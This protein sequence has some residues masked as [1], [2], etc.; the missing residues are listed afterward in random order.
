[1]TAT[2]VLDVVE[3]DSGTLEDA[4][5]IDPTPSRLQCAELALVAF[6]DAVEDE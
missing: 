1:M 5:G 6:R 2:P 4:V 3:W